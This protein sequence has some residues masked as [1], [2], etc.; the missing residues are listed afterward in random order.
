[1]SDIL[2]FP[3]LKPPRPVLSAVPRTPRP[4][5][6]EALAG[7]RVDPLTPTV[8][9]ERW[10]LDVVT[11][12]QLKAAEVRHEGRLIAWL[13]Y[14]MSRRRGFSASVMPPLT[15][16][17]GPAM[18]EGKGSSNKRWL[19]RLDLTGELVG[20]LPRL[21]LFSQT[22]HPDT[23]DVLGFQAKGFDSFVQFSAEIPA[24][25]TEAAWRGM[26]DKTRN[27]IRRAQERGRL[28]KVLDPHEFTRFYASNLAAVGDASY[29]DLN[30]IAPLFEAARSRDQAQILGVRD[31]A[32]EMVAAVFYVWDARRQWY[33][34]SS[35]N[36]RLPDN[37]AVSLLIWQGM[38]DAAQRGLTFDFDG[39]ASSGAAR[40]FAGFGA[41]VK[42]RFA[43]YRR[44]PAFAV[45][46]SLAACA[47]GGWSR[48]HFTS[49]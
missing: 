12:G 31:C 35:R 26:R 34:L 13:P 46:D 21:G 40:F 25:P 16:L 42:P 39:I 20:Q 43:V 28:E 37:G 1:M 24:Q 27:V 6:V 15:H 41:Q 38:Q 45:V 2:S 14:V 29:F 36:P 47:R 19:H 23:G 17:L 4:A 9:H 48:S 32:G 10:W 49:P 30:L 18:D 33:F 3:A 5:Q 11:N 7:D 22:C 8:F 44:S